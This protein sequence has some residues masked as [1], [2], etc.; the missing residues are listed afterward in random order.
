MVIP[1]RLYTDQGYVPATLRQQLTPTQRTILDCLYTRH[2]DGHLRQA[3]LRKVIGSP[4]SWVVPFVVQMI[5]EYVVQIMVDIWKSLDEPT[6]PH[7]ARARAYTEFVRGNAGF[8]ELTAQR[9]H[10]YWD[11]YFRRQYLSR[12]HSPGYAL[13]ARLLADSTA[14]VPFRPQRCSAVRSITPE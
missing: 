2:H 8:M 4:E 13:L 5:G 12:D 10:S 6:Y 14:K 7:S 11:C 9:V 3:Y 1:Y